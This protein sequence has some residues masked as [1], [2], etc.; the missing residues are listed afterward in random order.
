VSLDLHGAD[1]FS[2]PLGGALYPPP[3]HEFRGARQAWATYEGDA[4]RV[5]RLLPPGLEPDADPPVL[6]AWVCDYPRSSFGPYLEA[7]LFVRVLLDGQP[8]W[9]QPLIF[10]DAEPALAAGREIWGFAKKLATLR[11][12][13]SAEQLLFTVE[14]PAGKRV[15]TFAL[16]TDRVADADEVAADALPILSFRH[17]PPSARGRPPAASELV[18]IDP[19]GELHELWAGRASVTMESPSAVDPWHLLAPAGAVRG[20]YLRTV[21]FTLDL[22]TVARDYVAEGVFAGAHV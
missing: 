9:Y 4:E 18:L 19:P 15:M 22:G 3:P 17:V 10:T 5:R 16:A 2:M 1:G 6:Q 14:R 12:Q 21:D 8:H 20:G 7:F 13:W 11:W